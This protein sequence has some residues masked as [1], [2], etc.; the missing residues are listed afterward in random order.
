MKN[1]AKV[2]ALLARRAANSKCAERL[3]AVNNR[4]VEAVRKRLDAEAK[5]ELLDI[6][7]SEA[8]IVAGLQALNP[9]QVGVHIQAK[10]VDGLLGGPIYQVTRVVDHETLFARPITARG[11]LG[12]QAER[13]VFKQGKYIFNARTLDNCQQVPTPAKK[14]VTR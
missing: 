14:K 3:R 6:A 7:V 4:K 2:K 11:K 5:S 12:A 10:S 8:N 1:T 13:F 9:Y